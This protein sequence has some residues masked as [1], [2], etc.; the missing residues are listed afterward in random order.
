MGKIYL[1]LVGLI[2]GSIVILGFLAP[3]LFSSESDFAVI[4]GVVVLV[5]YGY[6]LIVFVPK[7]FNSIK[8]LFNKNEKNEI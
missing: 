1:Q 2:L 5:A 8:S 7:I 3:F 4:L 6:A